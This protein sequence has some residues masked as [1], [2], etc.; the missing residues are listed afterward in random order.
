MPYDRCTLY[1]RLQQYG[2]SA[3]YDWLQGFMT[4]SVVSH[5]PVPLDTGSRNYLDVSVI[6]EHE[7][8]A[9]RFVKITGSTC[10][11]DSGGPLFLGETIVAINTW[12]SSMRCTAPSFSYR[13]DT[14]TAQA[15]LDLYL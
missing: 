6:T 3:G 2:H 8:F 7:A 11:G 14:P 5:A 12:T 1:T 10:F 15:F 4:G 9:D 13:L